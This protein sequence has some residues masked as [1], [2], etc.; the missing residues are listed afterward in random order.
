MGP[1]QFGN[2]LTAN[3]HVADQE[4]ATHLFVRDC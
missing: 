1:I 2:V 4:D 3:K